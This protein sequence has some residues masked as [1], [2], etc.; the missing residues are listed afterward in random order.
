MRPRPLDDLADT[1]LRQHPC[2]REPG[3]KP[4]SA[5]R[6]FVSPA[7][8][9]CRRLDATEY[10]LTG[11]RTYVILQLVDAHSRHAVAS[12]AA[13]GETAED[14]IAVFDKPVAAHGVPGRLLSDDVL[15]LD[16]ARRGLVGRL[17]AHVAVRATEAI[18]GKPDN[19]T[20]PGRRSPPSGPGRTRPPISPPTHASER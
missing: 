8:N 3:K 5:C 4:R 12:R 9:S 17:V 7:L 14:A 11:G 19:P 18:T 10:A 6:R 2:R 16:P 1:D 15:A 20:A 13:A